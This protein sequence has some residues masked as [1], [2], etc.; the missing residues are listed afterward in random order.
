MKLSSVIRNNSLC[1]LLL[2]NLIMLFSCNSNNSSNENSDDTTQNIVQEEAVAP[3]EI[4]MEDRVQSLL[5]PNEQYVEP[6][7]EEYKRFSI[8][9]TEGDSSFPKYIYHVQGSHGSH[10]SSYIEICGVKYLLLDNTCS[11]RCNKGVINIKADSPQGP[12]FISITSDNSITWSAN[13]GWYPD[14]ELLERWRESQK[15]DKK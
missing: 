11:V 1:T 8:E 12:V 6:N 14:R 13:Y 4:P 10:Y 15:N 3:A 5:K 7:I 2:C 9:L